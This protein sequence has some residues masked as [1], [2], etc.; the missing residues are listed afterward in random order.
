[1]VVASK[2][3]CH[4]RRAA[5][6]AG[7]GSLPTLPEA[8]SN[9]AL[10]GHHYASRLEDR[11]LLRTTTVLG[12]LILLSP[13]RRTSSVQYDILCRPKSQRQSGSDA[14][15]GRSSSV[16]ASTQLISAVPLVTDAS[17]YS[18][19][20]QRNHQGAAYIHAR[21]RSRLGT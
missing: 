20:H 5:R 17:P 21:A 8:C 19:A 3:E 12:A 18:P 7:V 9:W 15:H 13:A 16:F 11:R 14:P 6:H 2:V 10:I 1:M 4:H